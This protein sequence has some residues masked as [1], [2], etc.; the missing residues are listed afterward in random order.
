L[1][2][3]WDSA[4]VVD[5][6]PVDVVAGWE[7]SDR[8]PINRINFILLMYFDCLRNGHDHNIPNSGWK[9]TIDL[10]DRCVYRSDWGITNQAVHRLNG[11]RTLQDYRDNIEH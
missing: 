6:T 1:V 5:L 3:A 11:Q 7:V 2:D 8:S 4:A 9:M 10:G